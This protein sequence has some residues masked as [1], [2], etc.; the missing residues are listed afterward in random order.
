MGK[1]IKNYVAP[2]IVWLEVPEADLRILCGCP[3]DCVKHLMREKLI[4]SHTVKGV[5]CETGPNAILLSDLPIQKGNFTNLGEFPVLQMLYR[6]GMLLPGHPNNNGS[7]PILIGQEDVVKAQMNYIYRGNYGL[8]SLE[9]IMEGGVSREEAEAMLRMKLWFA[10]GVIHPSEELLEAHIVGDQPTEIGSGVTVLR[11]ETNRYEFRYRGSSEVIDLNLEPHENYATPY[12]LGSHRFERQ[13]FS[14]AHTGEGDGWDINRPCMGSIVCFQ[15]KIYLIDAGPNI[16]HSLNAMG[17]STNEIE[18]IFHTHTHDDHFAGLTTLIRADH[19]IKY[20]A[21]P[22]VRESVTRK[23]S[24]LM[25]L[26][27]GEFEEFFEVHDLQFDQWNDIQ[28]LEVMPIFSPHPVETNVFHFRA[29]WSEGYVS[30]A[31]LADIASVEV[32]QKMVSEDQSQPGIS[33]EFFETTL[34]H[35]HVHAD[36]KKI[37]IGGGLI[38]GVAEDFREDPSDKIILAH[39]AERLKPNQKEIGSE[40]AFGSIDVLIPGTQDYVLEQANNYLQIFYPTIPQHDLQM[41]LNCERQRFSAG[42]IMLKNN[43]TPS[44]VHLLL[45]GNAEYIRAH[46]HSVRRLSSGSLIGDLW[47]LFRGRNQ[48]TYRAFSHLETLAIPA[49]LYREFVNRNRIYPQIQK[50]QNVIDF[51]METSIL[52]EGISYPIQLKLANQAQ[53][54]TGKAL[55]DVPGLKVLQRGEAELRRQGKVLQPMLPGAF[56]GESS[57]LQRSSDLEVFVAPDARV[58]HFPDVEML[59]EIPILRWK[60]LEHLEELRRIY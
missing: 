28:G 16:D 3:A 14:V 32:L 19:R 59:K 38:H 41:L 15:G 44:F 53:L 60:L 21:T 33:N 35:Y 29:L 26:N 1:I 55:M 17:I 49:D 39:T 36:L 40:A 25:T 46:D 8:T 5:S 50:F 43:E 52:G 37:D 6:Q 42:E 10:F 45:T 4:R 47:A 58:F 56:W 11:L 54:V 22:L 51:M 9:E 18:G 31:H 34:K 2:G 23:L 24:A 27:E 30:Y 57:I 13:Y 48:G 12:E 7:K 20:Y